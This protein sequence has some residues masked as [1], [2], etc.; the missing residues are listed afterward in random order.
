MPVAAGD[1]WQ[2]TIVA[3]S[4]GQLYEN[5]FMMRDRSVSPSTDAAVKAAAQSFWTEY[6]KMISH[7][8]S[9]QHIELKRMTPVAFDSLFTGA[10]SGETNGSEPDDPCNSTV[11]IVVTLRTGVS[12]K[13]HRGRCYQPGVDVGAT[14]SFENTIN[15]TALARYQGVWDGILTKFGDA[16]GTDPTLALGIYSRK[17]GGTSPHTVAGWQAVTQ[18]VVNSIL[19]NQRRRR[20]G[21]GV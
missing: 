9:L 5:V 3:T 21:V 15:P 10:A 20:L 19:G 13:S 6:R 7:M 12:G 4:L 14:G 11:S 17:I 18:A 1:L 2:M 16:A 8:L